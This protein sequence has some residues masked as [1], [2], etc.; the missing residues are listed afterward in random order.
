MTYLRRSATSGGGGASVTSIAQE[1]YSKLYRNLTDKQKLDVRTVQQHQHKWTN[2]HSNERVFAVK[3]VQE[4]IVSSINRDAAPCSMCQ[5]LQKDPNFQ[6]AL[7][8]PLPKETD[9]IY[10]N[11]QYRG[12]AISQIYARSIGI[13]DLVETSDAKNTPCIKYAQGVLSGKFKDFGVFTGLVEAMVTKVDKLGRGVGMQNFQYAPAWDEFCRLI[14]IHS[15][16]A[17]QAMDEHLAIRSSRNFR[18]KEAREPRFSAVINER[19]FQLAAK[20]LDA[21]DYSGPLGLSCDDTKLHASLHLY[22]DGVEQAYFLIGGTD[23][24][25]RVADPEQISNELRSG[26]TEKALKVHLWSVTVPLP[27]VTPI[28]LAV[29][30]ISSEMSAEQLLVLLKMILDGLIKQGC[31]VISYACDGTEVERSVQRKFTSECVNHGDYLTTTIP[32]PDGGEDLT[33]ITPRYKNQLIVMIQDSKHTLKT[34][35]NNAFTGA[36]LMVIGNHTFSY[37]DF[38]MLALHP[39]S[40]M[41]HRDVEKLDQ[42]DNNAAARMFAADTLDF[43]ARHFH[44]KIE[45]IIFL[46]VFGELIDAYQHRSI[47]HNERLLLVLRARYFLDA[48]E[49]YLTLTKHKL[50]QHFLSREA[51]DILHYIINGFI[52]LIVVHHDHLD[53]AFPL[54]PWLHSTEACEHVFGEARCVVKDFTM[55]DFLHMVPKLQVRIR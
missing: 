4:V 55:L 1:K 2:D 48:W 20:W 39:G 15:L 38:H 16:R 3:C 19:T 23:G 50:A 18:L 52:G 13:K 40:P 6:K 28:I 34:L 31:K 17:Y 26:T 41:Y 8:V 30:A 42:Q 32:H 27:G 49:K 43:A 44:N 25:I 7:S 24:P 11:Q 29:R 21:L 51:V 54:L 10:L 33:I 36:K 47:T 12:Q 14:L 22:W 37:Q 53:D 9:Y 46:F 5:S 45:L 35:H